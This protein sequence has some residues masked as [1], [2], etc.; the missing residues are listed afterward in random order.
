MRQSRKQRAFIKF[1]GAALSV[2]LLAI[3]VASAW[4][5]VHYQNLRMG[6]SITNGAAVYREHVPNTTAVLIEG[7]WKLEA[8]RA[9]SW[10]HWWFSF[11]AW[12]SGIYII[13]P[14][15]PFAVVMS[16]RTAIPW[17]QDARLARRARIGLCGNCRYDR[18][19]LPAD[20]V[21]P[22]CGTKPMQAT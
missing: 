6:F 15:W 18:R 8:Q 22:E 12:W 9:D 17:W 2:L 14:I 19:G 1:G 10:L 13:A 5:E 21:C 7:P 4:W 16:V 11:R 20:A 3:W